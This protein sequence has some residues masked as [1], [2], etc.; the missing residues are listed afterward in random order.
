M[1]GGSSR[2]DECYTRMSPLIFFKI[3]KLK[4]E[5]I[6]SQKATDSKHML[7]YMHTSKHLQL[8]LCS[9]TDGFS[10]FKM[11]LGAKHPPHE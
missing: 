7:T 5:K 9:Y 2:V 6:C 3:N 4:E 1:N 8:C 10:R 11:L